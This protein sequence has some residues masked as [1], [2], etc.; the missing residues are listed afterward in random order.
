[1]DGDSVVGNVNSNDGQAKFDR[2]NGKPN[3][4]IGVGL[5]TRR[6]ITAPT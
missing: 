4:G 2:D 6:V 3:D 5:V 1:M